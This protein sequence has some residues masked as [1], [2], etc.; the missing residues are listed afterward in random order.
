MY[1]RLSRV[2]LG[3]AFATAAPCR[4]LRGAPFSAI[5]TDFFFFFSD[6][7]A[8]PRGL[9]GSQLSSR[10]LFGSQLSWIPYQTTQQELE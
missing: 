10:K 7:A 8:A 5:F 4:F 1:P 2:I 3:T 9:V 6:A